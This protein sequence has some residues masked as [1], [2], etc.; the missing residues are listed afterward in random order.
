MLVRE[1]FLNTRYFDTIKFNSLKIVHSRISRIT[2]QIAQ[3]G[4]NIILADTY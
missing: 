1:K 2:R 4:A 3:P